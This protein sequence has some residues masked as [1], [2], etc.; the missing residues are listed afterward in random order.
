MNGLGEHC[1]CLFGRLPQYFHHF[2][3]P[4]AL[5]KHSQILAKRHFW[6][7]SLRLNLKAFVS[8]IE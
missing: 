6:L 7:D 1:E 2:A 4:G 3:A 8:R 5:G